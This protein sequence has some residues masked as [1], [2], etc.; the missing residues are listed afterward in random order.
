MKQLV[1]EVPQKPNNMKDHIPFLAKKE[2]PVGI[3]A[4]SPFFKKPKSCESANKAKSSILPPTE[5]SKVVNPPVSHNVTS[6]RDTSILGCPSV[7]ASMTTQVSSK[8][9]SKA[10]HL[11]T[12]NLSTTHGQGGRNS[13]GIFPFSFMSL[14][15]GV[16]LRLTCCWLTWCRLTS[17]C[18]F[19]IL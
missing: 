5:E 9:E 1:N 13:L 15:L 16:S 8:E 2:G 12:G 7:T 17:F 19:R 14:L 6:D 11:T 10:Q 4:K 18:F 3:L